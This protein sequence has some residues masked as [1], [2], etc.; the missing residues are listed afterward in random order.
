MAAAVKSALNGIL[1]GKPSTT[2]TTTTSS[3]TPRTN[4]ASTNGHHRQ[5]NGTFTTNG[6]NNSTSQIEGNYGFEKYKFPFKVH[7]CDLLPPDAHPELTHYEGFNPSST[8][9]PKGHIKNKGWK[10]LPCDMHYERDVTVTMRDGIKLY[11]D[12]FRPVTE[13]KVPAILPYSP[14]GKSGTGDIT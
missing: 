8:I 9:L 4:G 6:D 2:S 13:E 7:F 11:T 5:T 14:Y 3:G 10:A 1:P 12:V